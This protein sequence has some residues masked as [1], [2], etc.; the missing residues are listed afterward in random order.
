MDRGAWLATVHRVTKSQTQLS[1]QHFHFHTVLL[2]C[3]HKQMYQ[4]QV[5]TKERRKEKYLIST[6]NVNC[7]LIVL[8]ILTAKT[9][10]Q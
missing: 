4:H 6:V 8:D 10:Y 5:R 3:A 7:K 1:N 2:R 9:E